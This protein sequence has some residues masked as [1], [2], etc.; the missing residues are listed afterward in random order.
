MV[1]GLCLPPTG[2]DF[3][4][5]EPPETGPK[6]SFLN[7]LY[8]RRV[9]V[10]TKRGKAVEKQFANGGKARGFCENDNRK[11]GQVLSSAA[12]DTGAAEPV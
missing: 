5:G 3:R 11:R 2:T 1:L 10:S 4:R 7:R 6:G 12:A 9:Q 8:A